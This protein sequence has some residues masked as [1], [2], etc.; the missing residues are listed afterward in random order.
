MEEENGEDRDSGDEQVLL[1]P[2]RLQQEN[3]K[4]QGDSI[5]HHRTKSKAFNVNSDFSL[6]LD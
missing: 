5:V 3:L 2:E 6:E 4:N 1:D